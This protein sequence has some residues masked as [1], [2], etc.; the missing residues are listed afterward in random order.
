[1][2]TSKSRIETCLPCGMVDTVNNKKGIIYA[3]ILCIDIQ[4]VLEARMA[5]E[6]EMVNRNSG[7]K[8][9]LKKEKMYESWFRVGMIDWFEIYGSR[10]AVK[11][12]VVHISALWSRNDSK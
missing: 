11:N 9:A 12:P 1:M 2:G 5:R 6:A 10:T 3:Y 7:E 4:Y 8:S